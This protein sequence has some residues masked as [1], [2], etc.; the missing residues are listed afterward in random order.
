MENIS[1]RDAYGQVLLE[2]GSD[3][4]IVVLDA[5]VSK[6]TRTIS[7]AKKYPER[8]FNVGVAEQNLMGVAAGFE[9]NG[10][11]PVASTFAVFAAG[12][13]FDQVRNTICNSA[14][15][16]K[17][18]AT[19]AGITVGAD[20]SSHQSIED[21]SLM[22]SIPGMVVIVPAD[23]N[24]T[25]NAVKE[26]VLNYKGPVYIRL[27]RHE[28][29]NITKLDDKFVIGKAKVIH[30]GNDLTIISTGV[31]LENALKAY[32]MLKE[33]GI[34]PALINMPTLKPIDSSTIIKYAKKTKAI[35]TVEEHSKIGGLFSAVTEVLSEN[36]PTLVKS[37]S[38][39][40]RFGTSGEPEEL[41]KHFN[42]TEEDI[43]KKA[44]EIIS[45]K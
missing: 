4:R 7:F 45:L 28:T 18:V 38:I 2:I 44:L 26:S 24:E 1:G 6:A 17:I 22:R 12:R 37:I 31:L 25:I 15:N 42:L 14:L 34:N 43:F 3:K 13:A 5:D 21:V 39:D 23:G 41:I 10:N 33:K 32:K 9:L 30:D 11:I 20:G 27:S 8:F 19:H 40:D 29:P 36:I 16:V 35:L